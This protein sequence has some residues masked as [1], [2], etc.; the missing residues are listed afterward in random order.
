MRHF[1]TA[2][3]RQLPLVRIQYDKTVRHLSILFVYKTVPVF[4]FPPRVVFRH[5]ISLLLYWHRL[6]D[7]ID[8]NR[9]ELVGIEPMI[10]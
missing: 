9:A 1:N 4:F 10:S 5:N 2:I 3:L 6:T 8:V 7:L